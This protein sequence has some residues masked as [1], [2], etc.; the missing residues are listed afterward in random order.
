MKKILIIGAG[1]LQVPAFIEAKKMGYRVAT[2]D[3]D[4]N[5]PGFVIADE[6]YQIS[7]LDIEVATAKACDIKPDGVMTLASDMP[8]RTV[9][10][11]AQR[12]GLHSISI[13][14]AEVA[15][16]KLMMRERLQQHNVPIPVFYKVSNFEEFRNVVKNFKTEKIIV[17]PADNSGSRGVQLCDV[18]KMIEKETYDYSVEFSRNGMLVVEEY[19]NGPEVS[20]ETYSINGMVE[21]IAITDKVTTGAPYFVEMG[22]SQPTILDLDIQEQISK[23]AVDAVLALGILDGPS[24]VEII[25]TENGPKIVELG[26]RLGGDNISTSLVPLSTGVNLVRAC[27]KTAFGE[28]PEIKKKFN[29][30]AIIK[31]I[32]PQK[33]E[34]RSIQGIEDIPNIPG[35]EQFVL[36]KDVGDVVTEIKNSNDRIGFLICTGDE[37]KYSIAQSD[38]ALAR[39]KIITN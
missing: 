3:Q 8:L 1:I 28:I 27:I 39:L 19:M 22:H 10:N 33:G 11:I 15:T 5:A 16:N 17:K 4:V 26:A 29:K 36:L 37:L 21:V 9:A 34:I 32:N 25:V 38:F 7:T 31:Y 13:E 35:V 2:F 14:T 23:V 20:V 30:A 24:H 6:A 12:L 18:S